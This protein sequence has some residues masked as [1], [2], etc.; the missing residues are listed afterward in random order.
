M[1]C[2]VLVLVDYATQYPEAMPLCNISAHLSVAKALLK[3]ISQAGIPNEMLTDQSH[4]IY[5]THPSQTIQ[6][7]KD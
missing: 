7:I 2:F 6:I 1:L 5:V 3:I 4:H